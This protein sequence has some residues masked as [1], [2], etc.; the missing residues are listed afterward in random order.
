MS[1]GDWFGEERFWETYGPLMF[2]AARWS[3]VPAV[4]DGILS[5]T[6]VESGAH[7]LDACCG[8]GRHSMEFAARGFRV[9]GVDLTASFIEATRESAED[10][11]LEIEYVRDDIRSFVRNGAFDLC[12]NLF[13][14]FGYFADP[15]DDL[16]ALRNFRA[17]LRP[18]GTLVLE[19]IGKETAVRDFIEGEWFE[20]DG[21]T[22]LTE[23]GVHDAWAG[24]NTRWVLLRD[25]E[26]IDRSFVQRLYSATELRRLLLAAGFATVSLFGG[27]DGSP[28]DH[29][30][31][32]LVA[33]AGT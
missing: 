15:E 32:S 20:R 25:G 2:D 31:D 23:F 5:L 14:S 16:L 3:E 28:Y 21:W 1:G 8:V 7:V 19:T 13:T 11:G 22:V 24:L 26:R 33:V 17:S 30:A 12:V 27:M 29:R 9:T 18:G 4:V 6:G 10:R